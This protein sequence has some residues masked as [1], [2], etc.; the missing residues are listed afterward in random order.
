[1]A[2]LKI[3][4]KD[5]A[6]KYWLL[7]LVSVAVVASAATVSKKPDFSGEWKMNAAKSNYGQIPAP[8][9]FVRNITH[10]EPNLTIVEIQSGGGSDGT[11]TRKMTTDGKPTSMDINGTP[12]AC[13]AAWD[14]TSLIATTAIDSAGVTFKD[15]MSLSDEGKTLTSVVKIT[16]AQGE[17]EITI[18]FDRQ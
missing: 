11:I 4:L 5:A 12:V 1:L 6:M 13:S 17:G 18:A 14:G 7:A 15:K 9:S 2:V 8:A 10:A 16:S 3:Q